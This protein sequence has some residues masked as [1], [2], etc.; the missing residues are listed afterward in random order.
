MFRGSILVSKLWK[1]GYSSRKLN[2]SRDILHGNVRH[3]CV[4]H[5][6]GFVH[7]LWHMTCFIILGKSWRVPHVGQDML[8]LS[9]T[10][11]FPHLGSSWFH[12]FI[13]YT[14]LTLSVLGLCLWINLHGLVRLFCFWLISH[15][16]VIP[17]FMKPSLPSSRHSTSS[18]D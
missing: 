12:P 14:L 10:H 1:Q 2:W 18:M 7:Q 9:W 3:F 15:N 5:V 6:E 11:V 16:T 13:I 8:T 17:L 4:T